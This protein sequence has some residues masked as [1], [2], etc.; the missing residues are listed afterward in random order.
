MSTKCTIRFSLKF[1]LLTEGILVSVFKFSKISFLNA[2]KVEI[3]G[4]SIFLAYVRIPAES[5]FVQTITDPDLGG[6]KT[7]WSYGCGFGTLVSFNLK[8]EKPPKKV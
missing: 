3:K 8:S 6:S 5:G 1:C 2:K 7:D 4:L